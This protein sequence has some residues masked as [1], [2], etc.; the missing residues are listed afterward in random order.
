[1]LEVFSSF[2]SLTSLPN[3]A[4]IF[5]TLRVES[6]L[7]LPLLLSH[8]KATKNPFC[9]LGC[10]PFGPRSL[11]ILSVHSP[12]RP[13]HVQLTQVDVGTGLPAAGFFLVSAPICFPCRN[14]NRFRQTCILFSL[15]HFPFQRAAVISPP[16]LHPLELT[17]LF[18]QVFTTCLHLS[19]LTN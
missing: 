14:K 8:L 10:A 12:T 11:R 3:F 7:N 16:S 9:H 13:A 18:S 5:L 1:M 19:I 17:F 4:A 6:L 15:C 2:H